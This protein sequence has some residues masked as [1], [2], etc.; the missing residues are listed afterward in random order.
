M[1]DFLSYYRQKE[2]ELG[3]ENVMDTQCPFCSVQCTMQIVEQRM[4]G[5]E[6]Y[7]VLPKYNPTS[8]ERV[9]IKGLN[10]HQHAL[11]QERIQYPM[12]KKNG[13]FVRI[14]W[15][16]ALEYI[17]ERFSEIQRQN[18]F[19]GIGVYGGGSLTNESAYLL[20]K[21]ARVAFK[22]KH[23]DYNG[24][25]CMSAAATA[26]NEAFGIDRGF[27]NKL[28]EIPFARC[29]I[30]AGT[31][32][33][34]CQPTLM[35][36]L[37]KA[38]E[39]GSFIIVIDPRETA[40]TGVADLHLK[41]KPGTD[42]ALVNGILK[43]IFEKGYLN[44]E[45]IDEKTN[46][47]DELKEHISTI[48]LND[49]SKLTGISEESIQ[50][51]AVKYATS[52]TGMIF[53]AR[54]VEQQ[55][56]GYMA[57]RNFLNLVLVTGKIGKIGCGY[58]AITGQ[59]NGQGGREHGQKAD[60]L[61]GYRSLEN[62]EH[63]K[64]ISRVWGINEEDLPRKGVSAY[65]MIEK[66][67]A[68]DIQG[69]FV[70]GSNPVVS[71]PNANYVKQSL[72]K[73]RCLVVV[74]L[75]ISETA[76]L[77]DLILPCSSYLENEGTMTN[78]EGRVTLREASRKNP[79]ETKH[80]WKILCE[81]AKILGRGEFFSFSSP[82]EIFNELRVASRGGIADYFGI[83]YNRLKKERVYW[84]CP[85]YDH[86][87]ESRLFTKTFA[88]P[89]GK[90]RIISVNNHYPKEQ[91]DIEYPLYLTTGR[92]ISHYLTG[93]QTRIS[94]ALNSLT[95]E[96]FLEIHPDTAKKYK[97]ENHA[98]VKLS[99]KRGQIIV[100]SKYSNKIR[101]DTVFVPFHWGDDQNVNKITHEA[102]DPTC[103]MPGF[104]VCAVSVSPVI[105]LSI[106]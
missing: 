40:T 47:I 57:V 46:G 27:T 45:F 72:E 50:L 8:E 84:P 31:N 68:G 44:E 21:F 67:D 91:I 98:L 80:D 30:L 71:N 102:L 103:K 99:S 62:E 42:A 52:S 58:G 32:I 35:P 79:G 78:L 59:G 85:E 36:Y 33:A 86:P 14:S 7:K 41:V 25:F 76:K 2:K 11:S 95:F 65:E 39:N 69:L 66:I 96:S 19:D 22:T 53:T 10:A 106:N 82:E 75:F 29:L 34:E 48:K 105:D 90:G 43:V 23:I 63:R 3:T 15:Q 20:G 89:D 92:I 74:D 83:T 55:T 54:G 5:H 93:E 60:Q 88:H 17:Q 51:A 16:K 94:P 38:K 49:I 12:L 13:E 77:A 28:S 56:D 73:L 97:V 87:G 81:I 64:Y 101:E 4:V 1:N 24:R 100:R 61:P 6:K 18:G 26:A 37:T 104:K 9:C 70:M